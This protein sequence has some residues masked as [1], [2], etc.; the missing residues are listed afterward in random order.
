LTGKIKDSHKPRWIRLFLSIIRAAYL[1]ERFVYK[2]KTF[3]LEP[4]LVT[5]SDFYRR[6]VNPSKP[7]QYL[8][9]SLDPGF[10]Y[11]AKSEVYRVKRGWVAQGLKGS[12]GMKIRRVNVGKEVFL[13]PVLSDKPSIGIDTSLIKPN[14][15]I[16]AVCFIPDFE[17]GYIYLERHLKLPK[18]HNHKEYKWSKLNRDYRSIILRNF[19]L[20]LSICCRGILVIQTDAIVSPVRKL[21]NIFKNLIEGCFS[22]YERDPSQ[23]RLRPALKRKFFQLANGTPIHCDADFPPL[24][25]NKV[26]RLFVQTLAK[27][28]EKYLRYTPLFANLKS[29]ESKPIQVADIIVGAIRTKIQER[30]GLEPLKPLFF[31]KRK[32]RSCRGRFAKAYYWISENAREVSG[33]VCR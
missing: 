22:G 14:I 10:K 19:N 25:P 33:T 1:G 8:L 17:A 11:L 6:I 32:L 3:N 15:T 24:T 20:L 28:E 12:Y 9:N 18:T 2:G 23:K 31:D 7:Y 29:H 5:P 21:E 16:I 13:L 30:E 27:Q 4:T 26:V